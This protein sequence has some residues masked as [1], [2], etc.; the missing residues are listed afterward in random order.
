MMGLKTLET[1][2]VTISMYTMVDNAKHDLS[3]LSTGMLISK[4]AFA[5]CTKQVNSSIQNAS[6]T[7]FTG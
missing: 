6:I 2:G 5:T 1:S 7:R 3:R 4:L